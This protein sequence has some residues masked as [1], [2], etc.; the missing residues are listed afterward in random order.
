M[1]LKMIKSGDNIRNMIMIVVRWKDI[2]LQCYDMTVDP[3]SSKS[4][5]VQHF[6]IFFVVVISIKN[7][8]AAVITSH[9]IT[10]TQ[11]I[12]KWTTHEYISVERPRGYRQMKPDTSIFLLYNCLLEPVVVVFFILELKVTCWLID[13]CQMHFCALYP[14]LHM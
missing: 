4:D 13:M 5:Q 12:N 11:P 2:Q 1:V 6:Q 9:S 10:W 7:C 14:H 3:N 8:T